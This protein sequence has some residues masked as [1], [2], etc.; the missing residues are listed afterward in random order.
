MRTN[1]AT[2][3]SMRDVALA[4]ESGRKLA[5]VAGRKHRKLEVRLGPKGG[6][7]EFIKLPGA[8]I[9]LLQTILTEMGNGNAIALVP[10]RAQLTTQQAAEMLGVSRPFIVKEIKAGKLK[11]QMTGTHRRIQYSDLMEYRAK[12]RS[13]QDVAMDE[14]VKQAQ[15]LGMGY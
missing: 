14:L 11:H 5:T 10:I 6:T 12:M 3:P 7:G 9:T 2:S 4:K 1:D 15:E 13:Q 8:A